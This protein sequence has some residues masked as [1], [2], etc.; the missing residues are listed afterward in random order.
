MR[1]PGDGIC[2]GQTDTTDHCVKKACRILAMAL[3]LAASNTRGAVQPLPAPRTAP[4]QPAP[5]AATPEGGSLLA[6]WEK[7][8]HRFA[9]E[10][11]A[12]YLTW[13]KAQALGVIAGAGQSL[14]ADFLAWVDGDAVVSATVYG[15][16]TNAAE[17]LVVLRS[18]EIDLGR[19]EV[20]DKHLQLALALADKYARLVDPATLSNTNL[21]VSLQERGRFELR[22]PGDPRV[23]VNTHPADRPLDLN[24][25]I[26]NFLEAN[27]VTN[28]T[29]VTREVNGEKVQVVETNARPVHA[30]E[31]MSQ[32]KLQE[33]FNQYM[34]EHGQEVSI[35]CGDSISPWSKK[36]GGIMS[37]F[38]LF[39]AAYQAKGL[40]PQRGDPVPTPAEKAAYLIR[41]DN[42]RFP[43]G[44]KRNW[45]RFPLNAPWPVLDYLV[46]D[47]T[48]LREREFIWAR[49]RDHNIATGYGAYIGQIA[50]YPPFVK[51]RRLSPFD[52][53][54][55]TYPMRLKDGGVC[56]TMS[57]IG[58]G[59]S[60]AL[61]I[62]ANQASQPG[63]SCFVAVGGSEAK[64]FGLSIGQSVAGQGSTSVSGRGSYINEVIKLYPVNYGLLPYLD[65][66]MALRLNELLPAE[67][68]AAQRLALLQSGLEA[69]PYNVGI[70][71][72]IQAILPTP[73][74]QVEFWQSLEK[75][76]AAVEK[77][78]C[79]KTGHYNTVVLASLDKRL[80]ELP[81]P[82]DKQE[83]GSVLA[84]LADRAD[85]LWL[86]YQVG[87]VGLSNLAIRLAADLRAGV[88]GAR[89]PQGTDRLAKRL[90]VVGGAMKDAG[91]RRAW[92]NGLLA[93]LDGCEY[94]TVGEGK[95]AKQH[96]DPCVLALHQLIGST[97]E[98]RD[99]YLAAL[100]RSVAGTRTTASCTL[101]RDRLNV[102]VKSTDRRQRPAYANALI[103][104]MNGNEAYAPNPAKPAALAVDPCAAVIYSMGGDLAPVRARLAADLKDAVEGARTPESCSI[105]NARLA[106]VARYAGNTDQKKAWGEELL[107]IVEGRESYLLAAA[108]PKKT[109][110]LGDPCA[111]QVYQLAGRKTPAQLK[112]EEER[113]AAEEA[114]RKAA[115]PQTIAE[116]AGQ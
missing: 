102:L 75:T 57:N 17:R 39:L 58:R 109:K 29:K 46:S 30:Y 28:E 15:I 77:P 95:A 48:T 83:L 94:F 69:N 90:T 92:A 103:A 97:P 9:P 82:R 76:L 93:A 24:D 68:P 12:A 5:L 53:A 78:G 62:P 42:Y 64:G 98:S 47:G 38:N 88:N 108:D 116:K 50:Q 101:L 72:A 63:H 49:F 32:P 41:N 36:K 19:E 33:A 34:K 115:Q 25:H 100:K 85:P 105:L 37:A 104:V 110:E 16:S 87:T 10:V 45:P 26:I 43:E 56:G 14:P 86:K 65:S 114:K 81:I 31:V 51:A 6:S 35:D 18:L 80:T 112:A 79:P 54:Y 91:E 60:I 27:P 107:P 99:A 66:R 8:R 84:F 40:L 13:A 73:R 44:T 2:N 20:R 113:L 3:A 4:M 106:T 96:T 111:V 22:I 11:K 7:A 74:E 70:V 59:L 52:F 21:G 89:T 55:D 23:R 71:K 67:T 1:T 61:G